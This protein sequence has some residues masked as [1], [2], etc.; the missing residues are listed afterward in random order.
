MKKRIG[1]GELDFKELI[2]K[3]LYYVDKTMF[4]KDIIDDDSKAILITR[5][6]RFGKTINMSMLDYFFNIDKKDSKKLFKGLKIMDQGEE[7]T[8]KLGKYPCI[9]LSLADVKTQTYNEMITSMK[10]IIHEIYCNFRYLLDSDKLF[11]D[12]KNYI[13]DIL[14]FKIEED[15]LFISVKDL[16][17][18][19]SRHYNQK[20]I[21]LIDEYDAPLQNAYS[22]GFYDKAKK[23]IGQFYEATIKS[24]IYCEKAILTGVSRISKESI[25]SDLNNL[26]VYTVMNKDYAKDFGFTNEEIDKIIEDYEIEDEKEEIK[27]WYDGYKMGNVD[28]I[29]NPWSVLKYIKHNELKPY[30]VNTSSNDIIKMIIKKS[31]GI[32]EKIERLLNDEE[33]E[34]AVKLETVLKDV[35]KNENNIWGLFIQTGYLKVVEEL[36]KNKCKVKIPN[37]E[38]KGLFEEIIEEWFEGKISGDALNDILSDLINLRFE[39]YEEKFKILVREMIS[40][41]DVGVNIA[42]NFY[43]AFVLGILVGLKDKY[44]VR[45]NRESGIGRYDIMLEPI[46]KNGNA[47]IMEFKVYREGREKDINE[48]LRNAKEQIENK[49][50]ETE[51]KSRGYN[52]ITKMVYAF[53]GKDVKLEWYK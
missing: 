9:Y 24:N 29:Y 46:E 17:N 41:M 37:L 32:K 2:V 38:I 13:R 50:Y 1:I 22:E 49:G 11:D 44:Y 15:R 12:E 28:N 10:T 40:Y 35:E 18:F 6:R 7:Y 3:D 5:P 23:Y 26:S 45:S 33:I 19:L 20:V 43:H 8:S 27:K 21:I 14:N 4:A 52:N 34:V 30:W 25:F 53:N 39:E 31:Y 16:S 48:T 47:F 51:L 42:E 36:E